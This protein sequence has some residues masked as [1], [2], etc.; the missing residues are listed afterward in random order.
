MVGWEYS[1]KA[2]QGIAEHQEQSGAETIFG[3]DDAPIRLLEVCGVA[4]EAATQISHFKF[5][6]LG[7]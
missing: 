1:R 2:L 6:N 5:G 3:N 4:W 7:Y